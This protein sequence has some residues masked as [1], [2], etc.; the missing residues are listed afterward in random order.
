MAD[1]EKYKNN[2]VGTET[3]RKKNIMLNDFNIMLNDVYLSKLFLNQ[4]LMLCKFS[5]T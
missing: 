1:T 5:F 3:Y 4:R 2:T